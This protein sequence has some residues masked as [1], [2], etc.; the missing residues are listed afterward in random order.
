MTAR[1]ILVAAFVVAALALGVAAKARVIRD[2]GF[3]FS[4]LK[5]SE[6]YWGIIG[7][8]RH[9]TKRTEP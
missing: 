1:G 9:Q 5:G 2:C 3:W 8:E 6:I 4:T 7:C